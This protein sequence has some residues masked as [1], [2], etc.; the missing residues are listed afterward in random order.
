MHYLWKYSSVCKENIM[1]PAWVKDF[2]RLGSAA[3][4]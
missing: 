4:P 2:D 1:G 3:V